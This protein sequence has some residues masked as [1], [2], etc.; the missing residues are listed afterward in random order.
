MGKL[1][2]HDQAMGPTTIKVQQKP[3][4]RVK[5]GYCSRTPKHSILTENYDVTT[6]EPRTNYRMEKQ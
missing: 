4:M 5:C 2:N 1:I 6:H 3:Q